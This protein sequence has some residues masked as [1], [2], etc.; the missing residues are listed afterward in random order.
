MRRP[1]LIGTAIVLGLSLVGAASLAIYE[2]VTAGSVTIHTFTFLVTTL[3]A[4]LIL[5]GVAAA[6]Q[7]PMF[8]RPH[9]THCGA[10]VYETRRSSDRRR[11]M[12]CFMCGTEWLIP[13]PS[14]AD[15]TQR[16]LDGS[17]GL[18]E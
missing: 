15:R 18:V 14:P 8:S 6:R 3:A 2:A 10:R 7:Q 5:F 17:P 16:V 13:V 1:V 4:L 9:C 11:M 12:T